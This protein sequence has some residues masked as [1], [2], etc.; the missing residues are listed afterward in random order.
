MSI[1]GGDRQKEVIISFVTMMLEEGIDGM[2]EADRY[3]NVKIDVG[4][5]DESSGAPPKD[6]TLNDVYKQ[7]ALYEST[8]KKV[9]VNVYNGIL[10]YVEKNP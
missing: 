9:K 2:Y 3:A 6:L 4:K 10:D 8:N 7:G 1:D 5:V